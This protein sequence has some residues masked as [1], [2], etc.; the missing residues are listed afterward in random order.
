M[1]VRGDSENVSSSASNA[2]GILRLNW[3]AVAAIAILIV[4]AVG[5]I[6]WLSRLGVS[7]DQLYASRAEFREQYKED[8]ADIKRQ[9]N[10]DSA[11]DKAELT[12]QDNE[13]TR[14]LSIVKDRQDGVIRQLTELERRVSNISTECAD[15]SEKY[16]RL[17]GSTK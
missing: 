13:G 4:Q 12:K 6:V 2:A 17:L 8:L 7:V 15:L 14:A 3:G 9:I 5:G 11:F 10:L 1:I 16:K